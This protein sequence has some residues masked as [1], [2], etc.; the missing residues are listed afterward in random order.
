[1]AGKRVLVVGGLGLVGRAT[2]EVLTE[3]GDTE[4]IGLSRRVP[5]EELTARWVTADLADREAL[6]AGLQ[7]AGPITHVV[8]AALYEKPQLAAGWLEPDHIARNTLMLGN[9]LDVLRETSPELAHL[10]LLQGTKAYGL[11]L[12]PIKIP[13]KETEL[14]HIPPN[15]YWSQEDLVRE[16]AAADGWTWS[17]WR[18]QMV[19]GIATGS[20]MN[21]MSGLALY[22]LICKE[23]GVPARL[24]GWPD[25]ILE[26]TDTR[27]M[28]RA[29]RWAMD[30][31]TAANQIF[32]ITNGDFFAWKNVWPAICDYFG[33]E[34]GYPQ[35]TPLEIMMADK[36]PVWDRIV[37]RHG[38][39]PT[40]YD[41]ISPNWQFM[42]FVFCYAAP[43]TPPPSLFS[44][45]KLRQAGF[46]DCIDTEDMFVEL[47]DEMR[48]RR[49]IPAA[50]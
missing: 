32:N 48:R 2:V 40:P 28:A 30:A 18:P 27:L 31:P 46:T 8:Y 25:Y 11:H 14:R 13:A 4:V 42:D 5:D 34:P 19:S 38:L 49:L 7:E 36:A 15:F 47:F 24:P 39:R 6:R 9:L 1:M 35:P 20:P 44:T 33:V 45:I 3:M 23:L 43:S 17:V 22:P 16:R 41:D 21:G 10:S 50:A 37:A 12:G 29:F 26:A